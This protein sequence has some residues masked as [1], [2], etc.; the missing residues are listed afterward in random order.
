M[1]STH[2]PSPAVIQQEL[3]RVLASSPF[4][5]CHRSQKFLRYIVECSLKHQDEF[6]K[7][8]AIAVDVYGRNVSYDPSINATVRVEAGRLRSRLRE[9]YTGEGRNDPLIID[10][11][12]GGYRAT[13]I[14]RFDAAKTQ[15]VESSASSPA[16]REER[17]WRSWVIWFAIA[18]VLL[19]AIVS[20]ALWSLTPR[21]HAPVTGP[22][23]GISSLMKIAPHPTTSA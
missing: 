1:E 21:A 15:E 18:A 8:F 10:V 7:E 6:L 19:L 2:T 22:K 5:G 16:V 11:P 3:E 20:L 14:E 9:Y 17:G 13:F 23:T 12:K 4:A